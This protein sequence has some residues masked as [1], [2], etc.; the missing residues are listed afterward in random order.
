[1]NSTSFGLHVYLELIS[2]S[3]SAR[4]CF[5]TLVDISSQITDRMPDVRVRFTLVDIN[6]RVL[7][8]D[9][10]LLVLLSKTT[11]PLNSK[12]RLKLH[13]TIFYLYCGVVVPPYAFAM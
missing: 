1:M 5:S 6:P 12:Q 8:R 4:H 13:A 10:V 3:L 2:R 7:A 11:G 9:L